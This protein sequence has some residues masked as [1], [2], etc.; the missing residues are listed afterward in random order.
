M[1][2]SVE[3]SAQAAAGARLEATLPVNA[4]LK[5][6]LLVAVI[7]VVA[8]VTAWVTVSIVREAFARVDCAATDEAEFG[9]WSQCSAPCG[10]GLQFRIRGVERQPRNAGT[11]CPTG[12]FVQTRACNAHVTCGADC[13]PG[14][15]DAYGWSPCPLCLPLGQTVPTQ[16]RLIPPAHEAGVGGTPCSI[17]AMLQVRPCGGAGG[18][19][20][21]GDAIV[22]PCA[23]PQ[24]CVIDYTNP[25]DTT[26]CTAACATDL[27]GGSFRGGKQLQFF[28]ILTPPSN[29]GTCD[30][31]ALVMEIECNNTADKACV[32]S[33][34]GV[35]SGSGP[36]AWKAT[37]GC[38]AGCGSGT[39]FETRTPASAFDTCPTIRNSTPCSFGSCTMPEGH[40][41]CEP[42]SVDLVQRLCWMRCAGM[43]LPP[44]PIANASGVYCEITGALMDAV[45]GEQGSF[46]AAPSDCK[47]SDWSV[48]S[49]TGAGS[50]GGLG[51]LGSDASTTCSLRY[52]DPAQPLGGT[53]RQSRTIVAQPTGG[54]A[55]CDQ[56]LI[57]EQPCNNLVDVPWLAWNTTTSSF[58][59][60]VAPR[61]DN[62]GALLNCAYSDPIPVGGCSVPCGGHAN[63]VA[64]YRVA[65]TQHPTGG[66]TPCPTDPSFYSWQ[67]ACPL[68]HCDAVDS[69]PNLPTCINK[70]ADFICDSCP[71]CPWKTWDEWEETCLQYGTTDVCWSACADGHRSRTR[72]LSTT[73]VPSGAHCNPADGTETESCDPSDA[74]CYG[75]GGIFCN[76]VGQ[77]VRVPGSNCTCLCDVGRSGPTCQQLCPP[78]P[79]SGLPCDGM[80]TCTG[81]SG[82]GSGT[83]ATATCACSG[84][85]TG[86]TCSLGG[87]CMVY[88]AQASTGPGIE[89]GRTGDAA[90]AA[91]HVF[92]GALPMNDV[93]THAHCRAIN[94]TDALTQQTTASVYQDRGATGAS[95]AKWVPRLA[96]DVTTQLMSALSP[97]PPASALFWRNTLTPPPG[98]PFTTNATDNYV[99][100][101]LATSTL[102][103]RLLNEV[104]LNP[105]LRSASGVQFIPALVPGYFPG[106]SPEAI[107][108]PFVLT[109]YSLPI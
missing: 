28:N 82:E 23:L 55:P 47:Y 65:I 15:P 83:P 63:G 60:R 12:A 26:P 89:Q 5:R 44:Q 96:A 100:T 91:S 18:G 2:A 104:G 72:G 108:S 39:L 73:A 29:G 77:P 79:V 21:S 56:P 74:T 34:L 64:T 27:G 90:G 86:E 58:E 48:I 62:C 53:M 45:C 51:S 25:G 80:G 9:P 61:D 24:N 33:C 4:K 68:C 101:A 35:G 109:G 43:G 66:G 30:P 99:L 78:D 98:T 40:T 36:F 75:V 85:V 10:G 20:G 17:D 42:P 84:V 38:S 92:L 1:A 76:G 54:G 67:Q 50:G 8:I 49:D 57:L 7:V 69:D 88:G 46:C 71:V 97:V 22:P 105:D 16:W 32:D 87:W 94:N 81:L 93:F 95:L 31:A 11:A 14:N 6:V 13:Q 59:Q 41:T 52:C 70:S 3:E 107:A 106:T 19:S 102:T 103:K 37:G